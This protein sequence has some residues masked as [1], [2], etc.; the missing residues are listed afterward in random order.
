MTLRGMTLTPTGT[1][2]DGTP[3]F[4]V[5]FENDGSIWLAD[6]PMSQD[7]AENEQD[8]GWHIDATLVG[9]AP[10]PERHFDPLK[11]YGVRDWDLL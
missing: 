9:P 11:D 4:T 6:A 5:E 1:D 2:S 3:L 8:L 10:E 7:E